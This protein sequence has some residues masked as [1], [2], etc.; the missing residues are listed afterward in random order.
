MKIANRWYAVGAPLAAVVV[1]MWLGFSPPQAIAQAKRPGLAAGTEL[2]IFG[3]RG[4]RK[5]E[6]VY[7]GCLNCPITH[8]EFVFSAMGDF[9]PRRFGSLVAKDRGNLWGSLSEW[10]SKVGSGSVCTSLGMDAP[11]VVDRKGNFYGRLSLSTPSTGS[12]VNLAI[13]VF[14][15]T[16]CSR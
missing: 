3:E 5:K 9:G 12:E 1:A 14:A 11:V 2:L 6:R 15:N 13:W 8:P 4:I 16:L 7:L 10:T